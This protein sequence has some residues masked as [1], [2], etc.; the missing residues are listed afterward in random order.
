MYYELVDAWISARAL[1]E[2][3]KALAEI[4]AAYVKGRAI[5]WK[6]KLF[7]NEY[8]IFRLRYNP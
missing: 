2:V 5:H 8:S 4:F 7:F 6:L 3:N 1:D